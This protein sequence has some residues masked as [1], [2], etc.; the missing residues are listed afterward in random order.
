MG[1]EG[2]NRQYCHSGS[3]RVPQVS[4]LAASHI[5]ADN[6]FFAMSHFLFLLT[7]NV[8]VENVFHTLSGPLNPCYFLLL[9][10]AKRGS[11]IHSAGTTVRF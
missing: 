1:V 4:S 8:C 2:L 11:H 10:L 5:L 6:I 3:L 7:K 9:V